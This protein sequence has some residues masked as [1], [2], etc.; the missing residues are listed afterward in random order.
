MH[1]SAPPL[2]L[3]VLFL[4]RAYWPDVEA[5]GHLLGELSGHLTRRGHRVAVVAGQPNFLEHRLPAREF[6]HGVGI[7]RV[8]NPRFKKGSF[9]GRV[10]GLLG[11][12]LLSTWAVLWRR[13]PDVF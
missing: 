13:R 11:Y 7:V 8:G 4:N 3:R 12:V 9:A 1:P 5:T 10:I 6:Q 2:P